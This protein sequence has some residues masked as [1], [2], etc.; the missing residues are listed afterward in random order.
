MLTLGG[1]PLA[2]NFL[3][4][5][6]ITTSQCG[7]SNRDTSKNIVESQPFLKTTILNFICKRTNK[8]QGST[9]PPLTTLK[10]FELT[11][12]LQNEPLIYECYWSVCMQINLKISCFQKTCPG[13]SVR[14]VRF[15]P[16]MIQYAIAFLKWSGL[17]CFS[18]IFEKWFSPQQTRNK[19]KTN[20]ESKT[21]LKIIHVF[22]SY[23]TFLK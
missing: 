1:T 2:P 5:L 11:W 16:L 12:P 10:P 4:Q 17:T 9:M 8:I 20:R 19:G 18:L 14:T 13:L 23:D 3:M 7:H 22:Q 15:L 21:L 6:S